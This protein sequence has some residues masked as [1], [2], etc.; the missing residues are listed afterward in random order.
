[1]ENSVVFARKKFTMDKFLTQAKLTAENPIK[2]VLS[3]STRS[4]ISSSECANGMVSVGGKTFVNVVYLSADG[5]VERTGAEVEFI[6]KQQTNY[7]LDNLFVC[8]EVSVESQNFSSTEVMVTV[9]HKASVSG[10]YRYE[11]ANFDGS[12]NDFVMRKRSFDAMRQVACVSDSFVV[13]EE[14]E[15]NIKNMKIL[16][17]DAKAVVTQATCTLDKIIVEG[18]VLA[19]VF[20]NDG[21]SFGLVSKEFEFKQEVLA[22][23]TVPSMLASADIAVKNI[24][25]TPEE[26][27]EKTNISYSFDLYV[28]ASAFE[29]S[30]YEVVTDM[31]SLGNEITT[32]N[33]FIEAK[34]YH[35]QVVM[36][37]T[38]MLTADVSNIEN[39]DDV[40]GVYGGT[41]TLTSAEDAG[42]KVKISGIVNTQALCKV[43]EG[44][45]VLRT[46]N[47]NY[48]EISKD[49][50]VIFEG[51]NT[52]VEVLS[53][54]VKAGKELEIS[55]R[56]TYTSKFNTMISES[57]VSGFESVKQ[58]PENH[59]GIKVYVAHQ[60][61]TL[62]D[63]AK[64]LSVRPETIANQ[65]E[66]SDIFE[67]G[68][69]IYIYSPINLI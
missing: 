3:V 67:Q 52:A 64:A 61:E 34:N 9:S 18:K 1:M 56:I 43:G 11:L 15:S 47:E 33:D 60:G 24:T 62:F 8:D 53:F 12:E 55:A 32:T 46:G 66:V 25:I 41:F 31:F 19:E 54:K 45:E 4:N 13:A 23:G 29:E 7:S 36:S 48:F 50:S 58:K 28:Q 26:N 2:K 42:E 21:E 40:V 68:E 30:T 16:Q 27:E 6:E 14:S 65:N 17:A 39:F 69:K 51:V 57:F 59:G 35:S 38:V 22:E 37:D 63:V 44:Y 49:E 10:V 5:S 20:E